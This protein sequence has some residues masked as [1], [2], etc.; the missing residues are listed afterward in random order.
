L[1]RSHVWL[2]TELTAIRNHISQLRNLTAAQGL[3]AIEAAHRQALVD[4]A[5]WEA[6]AAAPA[7]LARTLGNL[8]NLAPCLIDSYTVLRVASC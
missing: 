8:G 6:R 1:I 2:T 3:D 7:G 5:E 4:L